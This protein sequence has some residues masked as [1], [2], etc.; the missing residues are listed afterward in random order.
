M[1]GG[2]VIGTGT[3][4]TTPM[5]YNNTTFYAEDVESIPGA[6][7]YSP[8]HDNAFGNGANH[9]STQR[10]LSFDV[11]KPMILESVK[12]YSGA[13]TSR[14]IEL[15]DAQDNVLQSK[16]VTVPMGEHRVSLNFNLNIGTNYRLGTSQLLLRIFSEMIMVLTIL[17]QLM[18]W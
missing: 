5:V 14:T 18:V 2:T 3:N 7:S 9:T 13:A 11:L 12:V 8:P 6:I 17:T 15:R 16:T 10:Y 1:T 4:W